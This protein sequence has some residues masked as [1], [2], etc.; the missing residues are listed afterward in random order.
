[1]VRQFSHL[2]GGGYGSSA[3]RRM[4]VPEGAVPEGPAAIPACDAKS[5]EILVVSGEGGRRG[6]MLRIWLVLQRPREVGGK[7]RRVLSKTP[8]LST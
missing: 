7:M 6:A 8:G 3:G 4:A 2:G 1:M 5:P